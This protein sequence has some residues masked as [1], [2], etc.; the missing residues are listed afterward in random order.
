MQAEDRT[1]GPKAI[2]TPSL[3]SS[4]PTESMAS[5]AATQPASPDH[6]PFQP[7]RDPGQT[8]AQDR[9]SARARREQGCLHTPAY[10]D[11]RPSEMRCSPHDVLLRLQPFVGRSQP[12]CDRSVVRT[13][14]RGYLFWGRR[15]RHLMIVQKTR[16]RQSQGEAEKSQR[17]SVH[18]PV[19]C[20][21]G[22]A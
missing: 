17:K 14:Q 8:S 13:P 18:S 22:T 11:A 16:Q 21:G 9:L 5:L 19:P 12:V 1:H 2:L 15:A 6:M 7:W 10:L 3:E 20:C 4:R